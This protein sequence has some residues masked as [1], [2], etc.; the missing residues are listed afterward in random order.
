MVRAH[1]TNLLYFLDSFSYLFMPPGN[2]YC[3]TLTTLHRG[4]RLTSSQLVFPPQHWF[5]YHKLKVEFSNTDSQSLTLQDINVQYVLWYWRDKN[6]IFLTGE[7]P[8]LQYQK[9]FPNHNCLPFVTI[10]VT[11]AARKLLRVTVF[12]IH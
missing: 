6:F 8:N 12:R 4:G 11:E 10:D 1:N 7:L 5:D 3:L 9:Y 2:L